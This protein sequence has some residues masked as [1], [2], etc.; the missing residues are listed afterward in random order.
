MEEEEEEEVVVV[1]VVNVDSLGR[2][3]NGESSCRLCEVPEEVI[4][5]FVLV[6][7]LD[8][9]GATEAEDDRE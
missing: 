1:V 9:E 4:V 2:V 7:V 5:L 3:I 6:F 8:A